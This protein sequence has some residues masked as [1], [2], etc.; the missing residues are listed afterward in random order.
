MAITGS[1]DGTIAIWD[2]TECVENFMRQTSGLQM[3]NL[4]EFQKRPRTGRGS[5]G[6]RW[7]RSI[8]GHNAKKKPFEGK[9]CMDFVPVGRTDSSNEMESRTSETS[10]SEKGSAHFTVQVDKQDSSIPERRNVDLLPEKSVLA[11][12]KILDSV[13]QSGIN[14]LYVSDI[15]DL[16]PSDSRF[17][18]YVVSGGDDQAINCLRC[19]LEVNPKGEIQ[20]IRS[21]S[22]QVAIN[23]YD[24]HFLIQNH[25]MHVLCL[26]KIISAHS[27]AVKGTI[28]VASNFICFF[29]IYDL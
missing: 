24:H 15:K 9:T 17:S 11:P 28:Q 7:W 6:G 19:D 13:H 25:Q 4:K 10:L 26:D 14:C 16:R 1:T 8:D 29:V 5:Q 20:S 18:F 21:T 27:S 3:E 23:N 12:L 22:P 2:L